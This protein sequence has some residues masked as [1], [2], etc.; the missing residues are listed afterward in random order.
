MQTNIHIRVILLPMA[1]LALCGQ[2]LQTA[3][4]HVPSDEQRKPL[5]EA[6]GSPFIVVRD[7]VLDELKATDEQRDKLLQYM[8]EQIME[9]G[10]FLDSLKEDT[11][12]REKKLD[13]HRRN[14]HKKLAKQLNE[15]FK[16]EQLK[17][18][19]QITRQQEGGLALG[20]PE[21]QKELKI[22]QDQV[23][24]FMAVMQELNKSVEPLVK[25]AHEGGNPEEIRPKIEELRK[26]YAKKLVGVLTDSQK[27]QWQQLLGPPFELGD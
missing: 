1:L 20:Q 22:T 14:A 13:E 6:L 11:P 15:V 2:S 5:V 21:I 25:Q 16:P 10:P 24:K 4:A 23:K 19:R 26:D 12:D 8:M 7:K 17:R 9:T 3:A 27:E 18:Y